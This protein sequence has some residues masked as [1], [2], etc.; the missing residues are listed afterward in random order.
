[1]EK[2]KKSVENNSLLITYQYARR[3]R[4]RDLMLTRNF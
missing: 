4:E 3:E 1:M 2:K